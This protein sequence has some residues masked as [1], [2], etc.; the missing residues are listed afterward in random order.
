MF[1]PLGFGAGGDWR[2]T[3]LITR[4]GSIR[5][6]LLPCHENLQE[7]VALLSQKGEKKKIILFIVERIHYRGAKVVSERT[8][9]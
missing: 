1:C 6:P 2:K 3:A 8:M 7:R 4:N 9:K 5:H